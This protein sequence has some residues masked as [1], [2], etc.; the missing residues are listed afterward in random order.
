MESGETRLET[1][2]AI[3]HWKEGDVFD[4]FGVWLS[5]T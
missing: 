3:L 2:S 1:V 5:F 4:L